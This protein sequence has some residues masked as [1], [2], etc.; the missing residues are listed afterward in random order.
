MAS[1]KPVIRLTLRLTYASRHMLNLWT[2]TSLG[3]TDC[4]DL[5][6]GRLLTP[7]FEIVLAHQH[8]FERNGA[9]AR[10]QRREIRCAQLHRDGASFVEWL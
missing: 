9:G 3:P 7:Q 6:S 10:L 4:A 8:N 5:T 1:V 2:K